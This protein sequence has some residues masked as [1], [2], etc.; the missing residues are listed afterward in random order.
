MIEILR[1]FGELTETPD[2]NPHLL[3]DMELNADVF[4][5]QSDEWTRAMIKLVADSIL[6]EVDDVSIQRDE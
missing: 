1:V 4:Q 3:I 6:M 5:G 2:G